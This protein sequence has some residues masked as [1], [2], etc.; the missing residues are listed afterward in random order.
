[1]I[2]NMKRIYIDESGDL[3]I[4]FEKGSSKYF[5]ICALV[6]DSEEVKNKLTIAVKK[7]LRNKINTSKKDNHKE[8]KGSKTSIKVKKYFYNLIKDLPFKIYSVTVNLEKYTGEDYD[9]ERIFNY[10]TFELIKLL[11]LEKSENDIN[12]TFDK[13]KNKKDIMDFDKDLR[14]QLNSVLDPKAKI[15]LSHANSHDLKL[16]QVV[17]LF[18]WGIFRSYERKDNEWV[19]IFKKKLIVNEC[20]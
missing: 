12:I 1:M 13:R 17:D 7:T 11:G 8:L 4:D 18:S 10:C 20:I 14:V 9:K 5:T 16:L 6:I 19:D 3:G 2:N 15:N